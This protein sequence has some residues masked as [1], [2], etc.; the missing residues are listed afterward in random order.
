MGWLAKEN[1]PDPRGS[2]KSMPGWGNC[3]GHRS[4]QTG[5]CLCPLP[6]LGTGQVFADVGAQRAG[7]RHNPPTLPPI[8]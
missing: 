6:G 2:G 4:V 1:F 8:R 5:L 3:T 7:D